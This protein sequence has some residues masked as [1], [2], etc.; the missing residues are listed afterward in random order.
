MKKSWVWKHCAVLRREQ[1][2]ARGVPLSPGA[3][4]LL[5]N[6]AQKHENGISRKKHGAHGS[7]EPCNTSMHASLNS[8]CGLFR[9]PNV[10][11][12]NTLAMVLCIP[13]SRGLKPSRFVE[14]RRTACGRLFPFFDVPKGTHDQYS[15]ECRNHAAD[16]AHRMRQRERRVLAVLIDERFFP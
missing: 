10:R 4:R 16:R 3:V 5:C 1:T 2:R 15:D 9:S 8:C 14:G 7:Q 6:D 13:M 12:D 11:L